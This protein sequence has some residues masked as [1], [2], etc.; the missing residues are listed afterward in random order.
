MSGSRKQASFEFGGG[1][2]LQSRV[3]DA[4]KLQDNGGKPFGKGLSLAFSEIGWIG[5]YKGMFS[6]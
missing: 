6:I 5:F 1:M 3:I 2:D 4:K